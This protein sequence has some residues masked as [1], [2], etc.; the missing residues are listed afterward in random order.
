MKGFQMK[1]IKTNKLFRT[2]IIEIAKSD[3][4]EGNREVALS[5][6]S[7]EPYE[8]WFGTEILDHG[9]SSV[10]MDWMKGGTA[11]LLLDHDPEK[12]IGVVEIAS[13]GSDRRGS[14]T[15][16]FGKSALAE[17]VFGDVCD[18]IRSNVSVGYRIHKM[19]REEVDEENE[20]YR[21]TDWQPLELSIVSIPADQTVGVGRANDGGDGEFETSVENHSIRRENVMETKTIE[22]APAAA[23]VP[24]AP[25]VD[26]DK[27]ERAARDA[28]TSRVSEIFA[29]G[30]Q[31][32]MKDAA[33]SFVQERKGADEFRAY[34][35][36]NLD[37]S[38]TFQAQR[39]EDPEI[40]MTD[41]E[42]KSFSFV[43]AMNA[44][45]NPNDKRAQD[46]A[47]FEREASEA[48]CTHMG[49][50]AQGLMVPADVL[51]RDLTVGTST[52]GGHTVS[53]DL[54]AGS[55]IDMLVN[56]TVVFS[57]ATRM[58][59][60]NGN[61]A[62]PRQ[63]GG[64]TAY[65][66]AESGAPTES[67]AA[68]DQVT[69]SPET[70]GAF[71]DYSRKL[72]LQSSMDVESFVRMDLARTLGLEIDRVCING[73]GSSNEPE[74]ILNTTGIGAVVGGTNGAAPDWANIVDLETEVSN[75]NAAVGSLFY[76]T[77]TKVRGKL[78]QTEKASSTGQFIWGAGDV[79][80]YS[81]LVTNQ[82]P[83]TLTKG[84]ASGVCSAIIFGNLADLLVGMW[85]GLDLTLDPFTGSTS[86]TV[87][88]VALQDI[89]LAVRHAQSFSAMQDALTT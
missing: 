75:D 15:V 17:E 9:K 33:S 67:A 48:A 10:R 57:N 66:V 88:I 71:S 41:K 85:G 70:V 86:G 26:T 12:Q 4:T 39:A 25:V 6:S 83:S 87:R 29:L 2:A 38:T 78:K 76:I 68:F 40:G 50:S 24:A 5:F 47:G 52:A 55:F 45:A 54:M 8:R 53:T 82:V 7:E 30:E 74:G 51:K 19:I 89:D 65:W 3:D 60:L 42:I 1:T 81:P 46:A 49:R 13:I 27:I 58:M 34:V 31:H 28:E 18:G 20:Q 73:S 16:R 35:L 62:I 63:T 23:P 64:A 84:S 22:T 36:D 80:G 56:Q 14:A 44:I 77:N 59:D 69:L 37:K 72:L 43:K 21:A 11:P 79:N 32:G 61:I